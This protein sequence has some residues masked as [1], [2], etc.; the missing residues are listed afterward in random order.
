MKH[1]SAVRIVRVLIVVLPI[2]MTV[3]LSACPLCE[4]NQGYSPETRSAYESITLLLALMPVIG[5]VL[6]FGWIY[7]RYKNASS[8]NSKSTSAL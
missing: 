5:S 1:F 7:R 2:I 3:A 8:V 6:I 4:D